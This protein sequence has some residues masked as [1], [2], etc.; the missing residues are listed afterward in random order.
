MANRFV[1]I[2]VNVDEDALSRRGWRAVDARARLVTDNWSKLS[3]SVALE[4][5]DELWNSRFVDPRLTMSPVVVEVSSSTLGDTVY[6]SMA[7]RWD[8]TSLVA[9]DI[10]DSVSGTL[11]YNDSPI[12]ASDVC[13]KL[14]SF[15]AADVSFGIRPLLAARRNLDVE[16]RDSAADLD[17]MELEID[18]DAYIG[19]EV[20]SDEEVTVCVR[21]KAIMASY[22]NLVEVTARRVEGHDDGEFEIKLPDIEIDIMDSTDFLLKRESCVHYMEVSGLQEADV[23]ARAAE[24][25]DF[26][27]VSAEDLAGEPSKVIV[28]LVNK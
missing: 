5:S 22:A 9:G 19:A 4:F 2:P 17:A 12:R 6:A 27:R 26:V 1:D 13:L 10:R 24:W 25:V 21:G 3:V 20:D 18:V 8:E 23:P 14:T 11:A 15:D 16:F 28:R 7:N